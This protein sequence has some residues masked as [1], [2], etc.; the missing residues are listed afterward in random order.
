[1]IRENCWTNG[2]TRSPFRMCNTL[3]KLASRSFLWLISVR[4][5]QQKFDVIRNNF[6]TI[7]GERTGMTQ[8]RP[9]QQAAMAVQWFATLTPESFRQP[10]LGHHRSALAGSDSSPHEIGLHFDRQKT[11]ELQQRRGGKR[12]DPHG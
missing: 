11:H 2:N 4:G 7:L 8:L 9:S 3:V 10:S 5:D 12:H 6:C 1:M